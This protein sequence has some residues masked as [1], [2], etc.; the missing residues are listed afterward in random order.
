LLIDDLH[1][2]MLMLMLKLLAADQRKSNE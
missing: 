1:L 2:L